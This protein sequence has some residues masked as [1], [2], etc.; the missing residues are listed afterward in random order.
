MAKFNFEVNVLEWRCDFVIFRLCFICNFDLLNSKLAITLAILAE[1]GSKNRKTNLA[2]HEVCSSDFN[3]HILSIESDFSRLWV[4]DGR[5]RKYLTV[6]VIKNGVLL[7][8]L[9]NRKELF[10]FHV[11]FEDF[12]EL[13]SIHAFWL[14]KSLE[15]NVL[16]RYCFISNWRVTCKLI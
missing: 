7:V 2:F 15:Y 14:L 3:K 1:L 4:D 13:L 9:Q 5:Q 6:F 16:G 12:K 11:T 10:H 8:T